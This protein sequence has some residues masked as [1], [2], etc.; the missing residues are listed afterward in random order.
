MGIVVAAAN[1]RQAVHAELERFSVAAE[2]GGVRV[3]DTVDEALAAFRS[4][5]G[6][7]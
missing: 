4:E 2:T 1:L 6:S 7:R 5:T 3:F